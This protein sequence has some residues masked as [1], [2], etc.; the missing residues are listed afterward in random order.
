M[1]IL[2][3]V[4]YLVFVWNLSA[5]IINIPADQPTIQEGINISVVGD[6]VLVQPGIYIENIN[7]N[8]KNITV[9]SLFLTT[10]DTTYI[11]QTIIDGNQDGSV[12][13]FESGEDS[14]TVLCGFT[15]MNGYAQGSMTLGWGGGISCRDSNPSLENVTI[16][17][18]LA[19][20]LGGGIFCY[21]SDLSLVNVMITGNS[22]SD[23]S[24][25]GGG[26]YC[27]SSSLNLENVMITG[28]FAYYG[29]GI[30][31][32]N[33]SSLNLENVTIT[34]NSAYD[35]GGGIYCSSSSSILLNCILWSDTPE[36]IYLEESPIDV[37]Y[38]N[39]Q[40]GW[41]GE[42]NIDSNPLFVNPD[43]DDY[44]LQ[45]NSPCIGAGIDEIEINENW[46]YA[47]DIDIEG[48]QRPNPTGSMPEMG[49]YENP[50]GEPQVSSENFELKI[51]NL[52]L[53]NHPNPFNPTT[54]ISFS[55]P[56]ESYVELSIYNIKG[57]KVRTLLNDQITSGEHS[58]VWNGE[59]DSDKK[60]S[61]GVYLYK[62]I[63]NGKTEAV[64]KCLLLK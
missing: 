28:N 6:T 58:I 12:V 4:L 42:G 37:V 55:V 63:V 26:I 44:H 50:L 38:S 11:S 29:G 46:Y 23:Y 5:I 51:S 24:S 14:T 53:R 45:N 22:T 25:S 18:N 9:A 7:F 1:K 2:M 48:N 59:D 47:P 36:E 54:T 31:C 19:S 34:G 3:I 13:T 16:S 33:N 10:Q 60:V 8:G 56:E 41:E 61:S 30:R 43:E 32:Y 21:S 40:G 15:I 35:S 39:I 27:S 64:K 52:K 57:Q 17:N 20:F 62:L 49:A